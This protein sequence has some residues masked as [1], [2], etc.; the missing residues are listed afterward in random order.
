MFWR[1]PIVRGHFCYLSHVRDSFGEDS[2]RMRFFCP[3]KILY[4][5]RINFY[6]QKIERIYFTPHLRA[7]PH[8]ANN[9][10]LHKFQVHRPSSKGTKL[11]F[12]VGQQKSNHKWIQSHNRHKDCKYIKTLTKSITDSRT[13]AT[14]LPLSPVLVH[15][16][17]YIPS[18][19]YAFSTISFHWSRLGAEASRM[20]WIKFCWVPVN[21][22]RID[23][24]SAW[25]Y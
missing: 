3:A 9:T 25:S 2:N 24:V 16:P 22:N 20:A 4:T 17:P 23:H 1:S 19:L 6:P 13:K 15:V 14:L 5:V 7:T 18:C 21:T 8:T 12:H 10:H 11:L